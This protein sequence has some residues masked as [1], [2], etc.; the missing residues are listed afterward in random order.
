MGVSARWLAGCRGLHRRRAI[1]PQLRLCRRRAHAAPLAAQAQGPPRSHLLDLLQ[2]LLQALQ[3][4]R[5]LQPAPELLH[6]EERVLHL[7]RGGQHLEVGRPEAPFA[8]RA[9]AQQ[10]QRERLRRGAGGGR[11][12]GRRGGGGSACWDGCG[13]RSGAGRGRRGGVEAPPE[14]G[15]ILPRRLRPERTCHSVSSTSLTS[16]PHRG[17]WRA[18]S[19]VIITLQGTCTRTWPRSTCSSATMPCSLHEGHGKG[20][21]RAWQGHG[22]GRGSAEEARMD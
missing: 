6:Q 19:Q 15:R 5:A 20:M 8:R 4:R 12:A 7:L 17:L 10:V 1:P 13:R 18:V 3:Q 14:L 21:A 11:W 2:P 22:K 16:W 9:L